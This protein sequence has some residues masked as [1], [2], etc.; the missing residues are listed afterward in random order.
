MSESGDE[1]TGSGSEKLRKPSL[2][3]I[4]V[5]VALIILGAMAAVFVPKIVRRKREADAQIAFDHM[6]TYSAQAKELLAAFPELVNAR[7]QEGWT[8]LHCAAG[9]GRVDMAALLLAKGADPNAKNNEGRTPLAL[10]E[11]KGH[12]ERVELLKQHGAKK[13]E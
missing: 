3:L 4:E 10:A 6:F 13:P 11:E 9:M 5:L 1:T 8:A 2:T 7:D 12:T